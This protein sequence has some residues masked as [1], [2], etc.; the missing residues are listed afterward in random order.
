MILI[1][2]LVS[3]VGVI[4]AQ[5]FEYQVEDY[6]ASIIPTIDGVW[7]TPD[8]WSDAEEYQLGGS[9]DVIFRL[10][11]VTNG[12]SQ[13]QTLYFLIE[14]FNDTT[15][16]SNDYTRIGLVS[17]DT[18]GGVP[19]GGEEPD[20]N[21]MYFEY[22]GHDVSQFT[23]YRGTGL[24]WIQNSTY[25][26]GTDILVV[27]SFD[28]S[29]LSDQPHLIVEWRISAP[30]FDINPDLLLRVGAYDSTDGILYHAQIWPLNAHIM[31]P[32]Q[33]GV[34]VM[35]NESIPEISIWTAL[36]MFLVAPIIIILA[37]KS[38]EKQG[39]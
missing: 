26:W 1:I 20:E 17:A 37:K 38:Q 13:L 7:T 6:E 25:T 34:V 29:P 19:E 2:C 14:F 39:N 35:H 24:D 10:K 9:L 28:T 16:D 21:S 30:A 27:D 8:E 5:N 18:P 36:L 3:L 11:K 15:N 12:L 4:Q 22:K 31:I 33:W 23:Y 32:D